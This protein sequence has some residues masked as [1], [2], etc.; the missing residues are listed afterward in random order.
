MENFR[1]EDRTSDQEGAFTT[2]SEVL[3]KEELEK[4]RKRYLYHFVTF[5]V[6]AKVKALDETGW[7]S[8]EYCD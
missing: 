4:I 3:L 6:F 2:P 1:N 8:H 5:F 7:I